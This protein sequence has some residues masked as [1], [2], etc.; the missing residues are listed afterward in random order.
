MQP[1]L[2]YPDGRL[3]DAGGL[4]FGGGEP[5][6][7]GK[8]NAEPDAPQF[9]C[10]RAPDYASGACLL[11][12]RSAFTEVGGFDARYA[13]AY[14]EDTDL[15][16]SLR[17][18]GWKVLYEPASKVI[19]LEGGTA[20]TDTGQG[21]KQY[22][23]VNAEKFKSK[24][25]DEL[26]F[27][28]PLGAGAVESWAHRPQGG[29]GPG[30]LLRVAG[31]GAVE[32]ARD[33]AAA[34]KSILVLDSFMPVFDRASG[35]LRTFTMLQ[36]LRQAGHAVT[37]YAL[38]GGS[39]S[40][41][42]A[43]G[44]LGI[45]CFGGDR[46]E[47]AD[48]G[49]GYESAV[50]PTLD[51]LLSGWHFDVVVVSP[52]STAE[53]VLDQVRRHAPRAAVI[54]D[55]NDV[56]FLRLQREAAVSERPPHDLVD[57]KRR[58]LAVYR[59]ADRVV[60]VTEDDAAVVRHEIPDADI[61]I[62]P[63]A[64]AEVDGG[65]GFDER[66]GC[67]FVGNFNHLPNGDAMTWWK[68]DIGPL[69]A[70][71]LPEAELTI[72]GNDPMGVAADLAGPGIIVGGTVASTLPFLHQARVSV[73]PLRYGAGM[74]GKVGEALAAGV[75]VVLT[76]VAA[77]G[78]GLIHEEHVL[79]ADSADA[80]ARAVQ[81]LY[82]DRDLW[83]RLRDGGRAHVGSHFGLDRMRTA[84]GDMLSAVP[85]TASMTPRSALSTAP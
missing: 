2:L 52:W 27:R 30:E 21:I 23:L 60:C 78:M 22:Q 44:R 54:V 20:G 42:D 70:E 28:T 84:V 34:A 59:R 1:K 72:I 24:W 48:R 36:A 4:V 26:R 8:G 6:I 10:R 62:V 66:T 68:Q 15:S 32:A 47:I 7:Y 33:D 43:V 3:N 79:I 67:L 38:A 17:A 63:N 35:G 71:G 80:F 46:T 14:Y 74:K 29:F 56:H 61:V 45:A 64:H 13:P 25:A 9:S 55:T 37:F 53:I 11:V 81:R 58:E 5:W 50:W 76:S 49:P 41:A 85:A 57:A 65:P 40:Y 12:R 82:L 31:T 83:Q 18:A 51:A 75:P 69:L 39:R 77:E 16:F 19:H 73:A